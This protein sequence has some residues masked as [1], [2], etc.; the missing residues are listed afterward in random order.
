MTD[1]EIVGIDEALKQEPEWMQICFQI[2]YRNGQH[3]A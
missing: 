2:T 1:E 3:D